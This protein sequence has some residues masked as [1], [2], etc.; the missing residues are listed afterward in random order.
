MIGSSTVAGQMNLTAIR[1]SMK[2]VVN[3]R[4]SRY[5]QGF[6]RQIRWAIVGHPANLGIWL[7]H[8]LLQQV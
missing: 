8:P 4:N 7:K 3:Q 1:Y 6:L 5:P 2:R